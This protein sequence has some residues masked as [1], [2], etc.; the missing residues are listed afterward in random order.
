M[1]WFDTPYNITTGKMIEALKAQGKTD[2]EIYDAFGLS[3]Y[4]IY[5]EDH[6]ATLNNLILTHYYTYKLAWETPALQKMMTDNFM[7]IIMPYYNE[8]YE[9]KAKEINPL[10]NI[11]IKESFT[12]EDSTKEDNRGTFDNTRTNDLHNTT[13]TTGSDETNVHTTTTQDNTTKD[14]GTVD[15]NGTN[16]NTGTN[17]STNSGQ[18]TQTGTVTT[19]HGLKTDTTENK[20]SG[21]YAMPQDGVDGSGAWSQDYINTGTKDATTGS[22]TNSGTDTNTTQGSTT[23]GLKNVTE[24]DANDTTTEKT[25]NNLQTKFNSEA[26]TVDV[27]ITDTTLSSE[28]T[29]TGTVKDSSKNTETKSKNGT[30]EYEKITQGYTGGSPYELIS[31]WRNAIINIDQMIVKECHKMFGVLW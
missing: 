12:G 29:S 3:D 8:L 5:D 28:N 17:T 4:P 13:E 24:V 2:S 10:F 21:D 7:Q 19:Q 26:N 23:Y 11:D 18:D 22:V 6:R 25:T 20:T 27:T 16:K 30:N 14:T 1:S 15:R 9:T 31:Q